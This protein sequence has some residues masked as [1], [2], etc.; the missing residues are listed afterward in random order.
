[1]KDSNISLTSV[2]NVSKNAII[3]T[4]AKSRF[5]QKLTVEL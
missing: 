1:M 3:P 2:G 5:L 4:G